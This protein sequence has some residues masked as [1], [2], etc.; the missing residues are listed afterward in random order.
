MGIS[1]QRIVKIFPDI[2]LSFDKRLFLESKT[3]IKTFHFRARQR[4]ETH[5]QKSQYK[6][7]PSKIKIV[8]TI[9]TRLH[10]LARAL[11]SL[12]MIL[13]SP[14]LIRKK[15]KLRLSFLLVTDLMEIPL[16]KK[17]SMENLLNLQ[18]VLSQ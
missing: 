16:I 14:I 5:T 3:K 11:I 13:N 2:N 17:V 12:L 9:Q 1:I 18:K 15:S 4:M 8:N 6:K 10:S 7:I